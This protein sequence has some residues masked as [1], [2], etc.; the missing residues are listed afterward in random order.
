MDRGLHFLLYAVCDRAQPQKY[1]MVIVDILDI[2]TL[3]GRDIVYVIPPY[4]GI[5]FYGQPI[6]LN[7][8]EGINDKLVRI[9]TI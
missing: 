6:D 8:T 5:G 7:R 9:I 1:G 2:P 3:T 4:I